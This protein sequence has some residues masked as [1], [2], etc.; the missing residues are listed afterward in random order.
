MNKNYTFAFR[1]Y[2]NT[3]NLDIPYDFLSIMH[4]GA[5]AFS[6]NGKKTITTNDIQYQDVIG[7][8][9]HMS[10]Y[11]KKTLNLRYMRG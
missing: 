9:R 2:S 6:I 4:Y 11:D 5:Y 10:D 3:L 8:R 7:Q 1:K